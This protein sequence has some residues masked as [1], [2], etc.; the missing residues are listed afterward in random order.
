MIDIKIKPKKDGHYLVKFYNKNMPEYDCI[1]IV[2]RDFINGEWDN[3]I[4]N[5]KGDGYELIGWF[6][7]K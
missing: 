4:Y 6:D 2:F 7:N 1:E 3:P 5:Y